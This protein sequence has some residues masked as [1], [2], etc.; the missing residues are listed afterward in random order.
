ML[1]QWRESMA[2]EPRLSAV[3]LLTHRAGIGDAGLP[4]ASRAAG[5][6]TRAKSPLGYQLALA[7]F[8][9]IRYRCVSVRR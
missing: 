3:G 6:E 9:S 2:T 1:P 8:F 5:Q 7:S 4:G